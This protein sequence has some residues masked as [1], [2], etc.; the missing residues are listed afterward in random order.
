MIMS[1]RSASKRSRKLLH[2][3]VF[4]SSMI[5]WNSLSSPTH[6]SFWRPSWILAFSLFLSCLSLSLALSLFISTNL[7]ALSLISTFP[8]EIYINYYSLSLSLDI[9]LRGMKFLAIVWNHSFYY[10]QSKS[11]LYLLE[12]SR[13]KSY[14]VDVLKILLKYTYTLYSE[15]ISALKKESFSRFIRWNWR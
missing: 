14:L 1:G 5:Q 8:I 9:L 3:V 13:I 10:P 11:H 12:S 6:L 2:Y 4:A 7:F 15:N